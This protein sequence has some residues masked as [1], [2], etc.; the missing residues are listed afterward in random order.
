MAESPDLEAIVS[1]AA[2]LTEAQRRALT[3]CRPEWV[4][5][6][7]SQGH[8]ALERKGLVDHITGNCGNL[9]PLGVQVRAHLARTQGGNNE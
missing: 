5:S 7:N 6:W 4:C 2:K 3:E 8:R 9:T 1:I